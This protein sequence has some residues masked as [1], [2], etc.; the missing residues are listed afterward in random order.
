MTDFAGNNDSV[1]GLAIGE[2]DVIVA[3][4]IGD[5]DFGFARYLANGSLDD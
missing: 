5:G 2:D 1:Q 4:G 3:A